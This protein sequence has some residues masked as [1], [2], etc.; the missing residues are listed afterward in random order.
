MG[1]AY[2]WVAPTLRKQESQ[3]AEFSLDND[4]CSWI[5]SLHEL[6]RIFGPFLA[7]FLVDSVGR[8]KVLI[9]CTTSLFAIWPLLIFTRS[10][11][12]LYATRF[13]FGIIVGINDV[14]SSIYVCE[15]CNSHLRGIF[16]SISIASFYAG[17]LAEFAIATYLPYQPVAIVNT[18]LTF[19]ALSCIL[20]TIETPQYLIMSQQLPKAER[21][22]NWLRGGKQSDGEFQK[23]QKHVEL[24]NS[25]KISLRV[26]LTNSTYYKPT[27]LILIFC[28][29]MMMTGFSALTSFVSIAFSESE[30]L[31]PNQFTTL[32]GFCQFVTVCL[33]PFFIEKFNRRTIL[34]TSF[35]GIALVHVAT[36]TL[37]FALARGF[38]VPNSSWLIFASITAYAM[39]YSIGLHPIFYTVR[40]ELFPQNIKVLGGSI[41]V[42][43]H[44]LMGF[45][46]AKLF[47]LVAE[48]FGIYVNFLIFGLSGA[49]GL[50]FVYKWIPETRG[51]TLA[52]IQ[53]ELRSK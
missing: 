46:S 24:E 50:V 12:I 49:A 17:E 20:V 8:Q 39:I 15:N 37:Y 41:A 42:V 34:L 53:E 29:L 35:A 23:L 45:C 28:I 32:F 19:L 21:N 47:L 25:D 44:S 11:A 43:G 48:A 33:S 4:E 27:L 26:L 40:G 1:F 36:A 13:I 38:A 51:K 3:D 31:T 18:C 30:T 52:Q 7:L 6:G 10:V 9:F 5:G 16:G 22:F 14:C 2:G